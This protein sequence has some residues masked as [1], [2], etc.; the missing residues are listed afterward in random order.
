MLGNV[1]PAPG[2]PRISLNN[3]PWS[4]PVVFNATTASLRWQ[5]QLA[6]DWKLDVHAATQRLRTD[7]RL[8]YPFGCS[9]ED[10]FDRYCSD[11]SFDYYDFH[12]DDEHR[13][14]NAIEVA[15]DGKLTTGSLT[16]HLGLGVL[17]S[18]F[19]SRLQ[20]RVD[21]GTIVGTGTIDGRTI[22]P[23]LPA[24]GTVP[25][26]NRSERGTELQARDAIALT[27][28]STVWLG[29]R[30][31][32]LSRDSVA[33][34]GSEPTH[35]T[36]S[37]TTPWVAIS[38][39]YATDQ[40]VYASWG[41]GV[42]STVV[43]NRDIYTNAGQALPALKSRQAEIGLKGTG[44]TYEWNL[45]AFDIRRPQSTN[46][47]SCDLADTCTA[48]IDGSTRHRGVEAGAGW[49][50]GPWTLHGGVQWLHARR[51]GSQ[52]AA[53]NGLRPTN[54]P[55]WTGRAQAAY[56]FASIPGLTMQANAS[57]EGRRMTLP[58]NSASIPAYESVDTA[59]RYVTTF[60]R[61]QTTWRAGIDNLFDRRAWR[62]SPYEFG[63]VYL[64]P[65]GPRTARASVQVDL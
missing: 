31:T 2:D 43:P 29:L 13:N 61:V 4:L 59:L 12:S 40:L 38:H 7:D 58:D 11:G 44:A 1:V 49:H 6:A 52:D 41:E 32:R 21:D 56:A 50:A 55:A 34:D 53:S 19:E 26:T 47:G 60:G 33:T 5:Q 51:E 14:T 20:D 22:I 28:R 54:V 57:Y 25:N 48:V 15:L 39:A 27:E 37:F 36:Q 30:Y 64:Y 46:L 16:H 9:K 18:Q 8:A 10:T 35:Y 65:L 62:E 23:T 63:H 24:L 42:E 17:R 3:Q 45:A